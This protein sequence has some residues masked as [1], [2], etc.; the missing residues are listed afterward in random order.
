[1]AHSADNAGFLFAPAKTKA[2]CF[3]REDPAVQLKINNQHIE[4][5]SQYNY[6]RFIIDKQLLFKKHVEYN[7][8]AS[9]TSYASKALKVL[10]TL[11]GLNC[12]L[13]RRVFNATVRAI[14]DYGA[15]LH[16]LISS[17]QMKKLQRK[18]NAALRTVLGVPPWTATDNVH[19]ELQMLPVNIRSEI[20]QA[21]H[22]HKI[23]SNTD[24]PLQIYT[25]AEVESSS[26]AKRHQRS[27]IAKTTAVYHKLTSSAP[28]YQNTE[29]QIEN[30]I[31]LHEQNDAAIPAPW[32][33]VP[34]QLN[35]NKALP[36]KSS[37]T[38]ETMKKLAEESIQPL[39]RPVLYSDGSVHKRQAGAGI[40]HNESTTAVRLNDRVT[41]LQAELAAI[42]EAL[43]QAK[44]KQYN[45]AVVA[46][47][48]KAAMATID[49]TTP[50]DN[51]TLIKSIHRSATELSE[52]PEITWVPAH[53]GV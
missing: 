33:T 8:I 30:E 15:E 51:K 48:S 31:P 49:S 10:G 47:D 35:Y 2:M 24:H 23:L 4:W 39:E 3:F 44:L 28:G 14:I 53:V 9:R 41:I 13:L 27:W 18:Q 40:V 46:T 45:T 5:Q 16:T 7:I 32:E 38:A 20:S 29:N 11:S 37:T 1:M 50:M 25:E 42:L 22:V 26:Q 36:T 6:L 19:V 43:Q 17:S 21:K 12:S 34:T 52:T